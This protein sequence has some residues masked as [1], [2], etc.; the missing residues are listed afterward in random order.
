MATFEEL[1]RRASSQGI[2]QFLSQL[3]PQRHASLAVVG[4][5]AGSA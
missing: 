4:P 5:Q 2:D 1:G 3:A